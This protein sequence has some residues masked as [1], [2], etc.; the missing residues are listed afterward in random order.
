ME[1]PMDILMTL[2][3]ALNYI[4][5]NP[6]VRPAMVKSG[7]LEKLKALKVTGVVLKNEISSVILLLT[8]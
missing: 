6:K 5:Q 2:V 8:K 4:A 7:M 3:P 1:K